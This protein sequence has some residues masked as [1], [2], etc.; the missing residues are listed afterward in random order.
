MLG[1]GAAGGGTEP[2]P[3]RLRVRERRASGW[4]KSIPPGRRDG[5]DRPRM[6][7]AL[8]LLV[9][10]SGCAG[11]PA[12]LAPSPEPTASYKLGSA[13]QAGLAPLRRLTRDQYRNTVR[14]LLGITD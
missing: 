13:P 12:P 4:G 3:G 1:R 9:V 14:D 6:N 7:R 11:V 8:A 5:R 10:W 2:W